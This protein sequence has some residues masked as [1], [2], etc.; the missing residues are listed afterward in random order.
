MEKTL[1]F[2]EGVKMME[3][4]AFCFTREYYENTGREPSCEQVEE[5]TKYR[6]Q[7]YCDIEGI[8]YIEE[9]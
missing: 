8:E 2:N 3:A 7:E 6:F 4:I 9:D 5:Y 1:K